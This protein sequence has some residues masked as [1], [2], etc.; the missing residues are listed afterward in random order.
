[1]TLSN[2]YPSL[3]DKTV[4]ISGGGSGIGACLVE[5]FYRQGAKVAFVDILEAESQAL[6]SQLQALPDDSL[7]HGALRFY[8]CDLTD[9]TRLKQVIGQTEQDLGAIA[10]LINN[11]ASDTRHHFL[12]VTEEYWD[13]RM[14]INLRHQFFAIQAVYP[15]MKQ[16]GGGS[17]INLG[18]MS[19]YES[20]GGMPG[21]TSAKAAVL[22]L[23]RGLARDLGPDKI[24]VNTLTPGWVMTERQLTHW[25]TVETAKDIEKNQCLKDSVMPED[26]A[27]M[28][29]FLA[30][31][32]SKLCTAQNF[33][34]DGGWI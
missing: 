30:S 29:L 23:T 7:Q 10:V 4:F 32:D 24:R 12:D 20:Q 31:D 3:R 27:A 2:N 19:W 5:A 25:V 1:M 26:V 13:Q 33:I 21:Y 8:H 28:A 16:L 17:I 22:G 15:Q 6:V 9:I 11:A 18:S 14:Q 34:V